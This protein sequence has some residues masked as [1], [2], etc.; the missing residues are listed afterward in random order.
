MHM[1]FVSNALNLN[2]PPHIF[3]PAKRCHDEEIIRVIHFEKTSVTGNKRPK[4]KKY[5]MNIVRNVFFKF[6]KFFFFF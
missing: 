3:P 1:F 2:F 6:F 5:S 4:S